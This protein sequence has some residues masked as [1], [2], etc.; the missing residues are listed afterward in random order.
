MPLFIRVA[1]ALPAWFN[2]RKPS[3]WVSR[4][5]DAVMPARKA[6]F[7]LVELLVVIAIIGVLVALLLPAIQ[8]AREAARRTQCLN[9]LKQLGLAI[10]NHHSA[11][12]HYPIGSVVRFDLKTNQLFKADGVFANGFTEMLPYLEETALSNLYDPKQPWYMQQAVVART[13]I[14][15]F[16]CPSNSGGREPYS[17]PFLRFASEFLKSPIGDTLATTD[18]ILSKG[19]NDSFCRVPQQIPQTELGMF[20]YNLRISYKNLKD[21][22]AKTIAVGEGAGGSSWPLCSSPFCS[23]ADL[24]E[25]PPELAQ[26]RYARQFWI[27]SGNVR[28][29]HDSFKWAA[30]GHLGSTV[31]P[32]NK[33]P[34]TH[35]LF[36]DSAGS[37]PDN[38]PGTLWRGAA[39]MHRVPN[40]RSDH[41]GGGNFLYADGSV[42]FVN[43]E[44]DIIAYRA[45]STISGGEITPLE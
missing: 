38:C 22:A 26:S 37:G 43:E 40:F 7:T 32:L 27:G 21:G 29:I 5:K 24:P 25:P 11:R 17:D 45:H 44:I 33:T 4:Q 2:A 13:P 23:T 6:G 16:N 36:D 8:A 15:V 35:F 30:S 19:A 9:N 34:I 28:R 41:P 42:R 3:G 14:A 10:E 1:F 18:Y 20:D 31:R 12:R 39:N